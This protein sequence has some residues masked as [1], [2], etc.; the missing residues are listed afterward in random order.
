M[1]LKDLLAARLEARSEKIVQRLEQIIDTGNDSDSLRAIESM[2]ARVY[3][4]PT[5]HVVTETTDHTDMSLAEL[6]RERKR[7]SAAVAATEETG[8]ESPYP[9]PTKPLEGLT[10]SRVIEH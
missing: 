3:G 5:E 1:T 7:L 8:K 6:E 9:V 10:A 4:K 2:L